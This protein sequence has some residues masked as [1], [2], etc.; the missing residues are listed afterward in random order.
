MKTS[1][2][3]LAA[4]MVVLMVVTSAPLSG[5]VGF[6]WKSFAADESKKIITDTGDKMR[7]PEERDAL[8]KRIV[9]SDNWI[10]EGSPRES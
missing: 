3:I 9:E 7:T 10:V 8:F 1:K 5:L 4:V 2:R 6:D